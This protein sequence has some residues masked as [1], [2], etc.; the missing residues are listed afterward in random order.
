[1]IDPS[2]FTGDDRD[3][4]LD[5]YCDAEEHHL[6]TEPLGVSVSTTA[7]VDSSH[8][9]NKVTQRSGTHYLV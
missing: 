9:A 7:Y 2:W 3:T 1:M 8:A 4:F 5:Q 6:C